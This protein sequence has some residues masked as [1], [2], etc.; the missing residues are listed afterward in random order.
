MRENHE[1]G[2]PLRTAEPWR[3]TRARLHA[4]S[5]SPTV[6]RR[7]DLALAPDHL[8]DGQRVSSVDALTKP[9]LW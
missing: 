5:K 7:V 6:K 1:I 8:R 2:K 4:V 9:Y 3:S